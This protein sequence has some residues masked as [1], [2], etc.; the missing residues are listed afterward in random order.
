MWLAQKKKTQIHQARKIYQI[1]DF[2]K[3]L[4]VSCM[5]SL[6]AGDSTLCLL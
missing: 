1:M 2:K 4:G 3:L 6:A 5:Y